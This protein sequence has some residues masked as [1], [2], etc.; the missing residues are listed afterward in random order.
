M[1]K[2]HPNLCELVAPIRCRSLDRFG[3][4]V[5]HSSST[6]G[7]SGAKSDNAGIF[8]L[9]LGGQF[10]M[11]YS[12]QPW[13]NGERFEANGIRTRGMGSASGVKIRFSRFRLG[14]GLKMSSSGERGNGGSDKGPK[15]SRIH[16]R[17]PFCSH[18][19]CSSSRHR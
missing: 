17:H 16:L 9:F 12:F 15:S 8:L 13:G 7:S 14:F 19:N 18:G 4:A 6:P 11:T 1:Q 10:G 5:V 3:F 2:V